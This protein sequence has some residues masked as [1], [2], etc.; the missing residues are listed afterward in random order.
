[1]PSGRVAY[2]ALAAAF[3]DI[4]TD[5]ASTTAKKMIWG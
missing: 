4:L 3:E 2:L 1:L 5:I